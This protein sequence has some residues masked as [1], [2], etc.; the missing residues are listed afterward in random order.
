MMENE[1]LSIGF[2]EIG[3]TR[4]KGFPGLAY[5]VHTVIRERDGRRLAGLT[6]QPAPMVVAVTENG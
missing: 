4:I 2:G 5:S 3:D 6:E 1:I